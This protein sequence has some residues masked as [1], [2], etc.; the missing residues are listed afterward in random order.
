M[1]S[2]I[3]ALIVLLSPVAAIGDTHDK[4]QPGVAAVTTV[5]AS[6]PAS[7]NLLGRG[8]PLYDNGPFI[9]DVGTGPGGADVSILQASLG[10]N[11]FGFAAQ[12]STPNRVA[13][14]FTIPAGEQWTLSGAVF[15]AYQT[16]SS[17]TSTL[18]GVN[19]RIWDG[20]PGDAGSTVVFG[21]DTSNLFSATTWSGVYRASS[22][23]PND[24]S[25]PIMEVEADFG[26]VA[27][28]AGTYWI[29]WSF[30]GTLASGPWQPPI[31]ILGETTTG[32]G[33]QYTDVS[34]AW[35]DALDTATSAQQGLPFRLL[36]SSIV[37]AADVGLSTG[38][39][40][41]GSVNVGASGTQSVTFTNT[42]TAAGSF[43]WTAVAAPFALQSSS[44][45]PSP[46][47]LAA[48]AGCTLTYTFS[49]A[50]PGAA[51][52]QSVTV[53]VDALSASFT[54]DGVGLQVISPPQFIPSAGVWGLLLLGGLV[55]LIAVRRAHAQG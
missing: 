37:P 15:Y 19:V 46:A 41:F 25:R 45:G 31:T 21:D 39:L 12:L 2:L 10:L 11:T 26:S 20:P 9:T 7:R 52:Q 38:A 27:L 3:P 4:H 48:G 16:G 24:T 14:D 53:Q 50:T 1:K 5:P 40:A 29:D 54:L 34:G 55:V 8:T 44:C 13:D 32:N 23:S 22:D 28:T 49:P 43:S 47:S 17:T 36:G 42:G 33:L 51:A 6:V 30:I 35:N 18:N